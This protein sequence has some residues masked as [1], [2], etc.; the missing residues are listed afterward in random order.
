MD[1]EDARAAI[2]LV[3]F[4]YFKRVLEKDKKRRRR[5][6]SSESESAE[7]SNDNREVRRTKKSKKDSDPYEY[8][9]DDDPSEGITKRTTRSQKTAEILS[10]K[11]TSTLEVLSPT[12]TQ[13]R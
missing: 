6:D 13:E 9:S 4:A 11:E 12:I 10:S 7:E 3:Q 5:H 2:E 8:D 1:R